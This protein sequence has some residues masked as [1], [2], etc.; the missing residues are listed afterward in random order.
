MSIELFTERFSYI[1]QFNTTPVGS[2]NGEF[3]MFNEFNPFDDFSQFVLPPSTYDIES[4][5]IPRQLT[6]DS[7]DDDI[8]I[9]DEDIEN[10]HSMDVSDDEDEL[11]FEMEMDWDVRKPQQ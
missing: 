8:T 2:Y 11:Q 6:Y 5:F 1:I 3:D 10:F 7:D 4:G 9:T